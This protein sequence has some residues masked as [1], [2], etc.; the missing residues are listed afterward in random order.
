MM[1]LGKIAMEVAR[2]ID[3][4]V[5]RRTREDGEVYVLVGETKNRITVEFID[6]ARVEKANTDS[7]Q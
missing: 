2:K 6:P 4:E 5:D 7:T 1:G 3:A